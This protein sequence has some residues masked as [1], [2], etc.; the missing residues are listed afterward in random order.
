MKHSRVAPFLAVLLLTPGLP[1]QAQS[2]T[3]GELREFCSSGA[4]AD[5]RECEAYVEGVMEGLWTGFGWGAA[6][7]LRYAE[8]QR[9]PR[10]DDAQTQK[11][12][13]Q[14][15]LGMQAQGRL[16]AVCEPDALDTDAL[17]GTVKA[18]LKNVDPDLPAG[19]AILY[20]LRA[21][22]GYPC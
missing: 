17:I 3:A 2:L 4:P 15:L 7:A 20:A 18:G 19:E 16:S 12:V 13:K 22:W 11:S 6:D 10:P 21:A 8:A 9:D 5:M 1:A 14:S